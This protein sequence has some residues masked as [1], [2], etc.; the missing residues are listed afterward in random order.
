MFLPS[1]ILHT[2]YSFAINYLLSARAALSRF[3]IYNTPSLSHSKMVENLPSPFSLFLFAFSFVCT[4][5]DCGPRSQPVKMSVTFVDLR[6]LSRSLRT[7][8]HKL[9]H[10]L[11]VSEPWAHLRSFKFTLYK[12]SHYYHYYF[13]VACSWFVITSV[14]N[15]HQW[16]CPMVM[17]SVYGALVSSSFSCE[18]IYW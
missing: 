5:H 17:A 14:K 16:S 6:L 1:V 15:R 8:G 2:Y 7:F 9:T 13:D 12:F 18:N 4:S 3:A 11:F 10:C